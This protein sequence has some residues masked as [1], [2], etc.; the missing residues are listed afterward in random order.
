[1]PRRAQSLRKMLREGELDDREIEIE[2]QRHA[3]GRGDHGA[4]PAWR[5][6]QQQLQGMF[7]NLAASAD[8]AAQ[9][10][11]QGSAEAAGRGGGR[12]A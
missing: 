2:V 12:Q 5:R 8:R 3:R 4:R 7:Q 6:W 1:M 10:E 9:D 11:G